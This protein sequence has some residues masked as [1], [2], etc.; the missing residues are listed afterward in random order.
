MKRIACLLILLSLPVV[1]N[2]QHQLWHIPAPQ[3]IEVSILSPDATTFV[4]VSGDDSPVLTCH[5]VPTGKVLWTR[6]ISAPPKMKHVVRF[7][8]WRF[9]DDVTLLIGEGNVHEFIDVRTGTVVASIPIAGESWSDLVVGSGDGY[10][11]VP[12][13]GDTWAVFAF[14]DAFQVISLKNRRGILTTASR[15]IAEPMEVSNGLLMIR[16]WDST[17]YVDMEMERLV[18]KG[19][20]DFNSTVYSHF[21][22][23]KNDLLIF[24]EKTINCVNLQTGTVAALL[25]VD[26]DDPDY[27]KPVVVDDRLHLLVG[28]DGVHTLYECVTGRQVWQT[29]ARVLPEFIDEVVPIRDGR[30]LVTWF[31]KSDTC[32][33][34]GLNLATGRVEWKRAM[35]VNMERSYEPGHRR[36]S[37]MALMQVVS[38]LASVALSVATS[39]L[40]AS[41]GSSYRYFIGVDMTSLLYKAKKSGTVFRILEMDDG[42]ATLLAAGKYS[43]VPSDDFQPGKRPEKIFTVS[44]QDGGIRDVVHCKVLFDHQM[45]SYNAITA[46]EEDRVIYQRDRTVVFG[47]TD[48]YAIRNGRVTALNFGRERPDFLADHGDTLHVRSAVQGRDATEVNKVWRVCVVSD[49]LQK[50]LLAWSEKL[51]LAGCDFD[52]FTHCYEIHRG[53]IRAFP[54]ITGDPPKAYWDT[55]LWTRKFPEM[56]RS[57]TTFEYA[58]SRERYWHRPIEGVC[59]DGR[60]IV[61]M[62]E[63]ELTRIASDGSCQWSRKWDVS[64]KDTPLGLIRSDGVLYYCSD[65]VVE[66]L[67]DDCANRQIMRVELDSPYFIHYAPEEHIVLFRQGE[68]FM[69]CWS[70]L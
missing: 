66:M 56:R 48:I 52:A 43:V 53:E 1:L 11:V 27:Y 68:G 34:A 59:I 58:A 26:P 40:A 49:T 39:G 19:P 18:Y 24:N 62:G 5:D 70:T 61:V 25:P 12:E 16:I 9:V 36:S 67:G 23:W 33:L 69:E 30:A 46:I 65:D 22:R 15:R 63:D 3:E 10:R 38:V 64:P 55:P 8:L 37:G 14:D 2:A 31:A 50:T 29:Q 6:P 51:W 32:G 28:T 13:F 41:V 54:L 4:T 20:S 57:R 47:S 60:G 35:F 42:S 21:F 7:D 44:L 17:F 45:E